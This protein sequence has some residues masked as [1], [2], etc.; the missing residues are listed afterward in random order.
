MISWFSYIIKENELFDV[1]SVMYDNATKCL[2]LALTLS[3]LIFQRP[4][5]TFAFDRSG[6][7][8]IEKPS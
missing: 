8:P 1:D 3:S 7:L 6:T 5:Y 4:N 2:E